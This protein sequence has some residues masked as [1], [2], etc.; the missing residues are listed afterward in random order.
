MDD[1][2]TIFQC[3]FSEDYY[4]RLPPLLSVQLDPIINGTCPNDP[5]G[6]QVIISAIFFGEDLILSNQMLEI[7]VFS[8]LKN[9]KM[10]RCASISLLRGG[11]GGKATTIF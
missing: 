1:V 10:S 8:G 6:Y 2:I 4:Y 11:G 7:N 9:S 5:Y 3:A